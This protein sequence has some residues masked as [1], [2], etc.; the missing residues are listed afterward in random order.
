MIRHSGGE[1]DVDEMG[2]TIWVIA[3]RTFLAEIVTED[4]SGR[5]EQDQDVRYANALLM[6][7]APKLLRVLRDAVRDQTTRDGG[8]LQRAEEL[9]EQLDDDAE[10]GE[11]EEYV[12]ASIAR[13][14]AA[15]DVTA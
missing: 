13:F 1:W 10:C 9:L 5:L 3:G 2:V 14:N 7:A 4:A 6:A 8:W 11:G 15:K 12:R